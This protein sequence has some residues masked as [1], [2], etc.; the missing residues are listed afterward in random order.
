MKPG[1][2]IE[3]LILVLIPAKSDLRLWKIREKMIVKLL[4][5]RGSFFIMPKA[6]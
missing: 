2:R 1:N 5:L 6:E 3:V 4:S